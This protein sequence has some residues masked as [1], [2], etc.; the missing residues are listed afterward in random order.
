ME[1]GLDIV[2]EIVDINNVYDVGGEIGCQIA[3]VGGCL[4]T[5]LAAME[6]AIAGVVNICAVF[7]PTKLSSFC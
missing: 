6:L 3:C 1:K 5:Q 7:K 4:V 2:N